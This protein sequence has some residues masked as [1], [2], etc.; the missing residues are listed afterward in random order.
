M[1]VCDVRI[2]KEA[3]PKCTCLEHVF[4]VSDGALG[5]CET[6]GGCGPVRGVDHSG[7]AFQ[8]DVEARHWLL[9]LSFQEPV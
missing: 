4:P 9:S 5:V 3:F 6:S 7:W 1:I 8:G 2:L